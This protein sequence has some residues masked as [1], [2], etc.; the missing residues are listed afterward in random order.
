MIPN[1]NQFIEMMTPKGLDKNI[2]K[3]GS[4]DPAYS[5]GKPK[6]MF[7]GETVVSAK[8]YPRLASYTPV[9]SDRVLILSVANSY[10]ILGKI[11]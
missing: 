4:I 8:Q 6:V 5:S 10:V 3:L 7:D 9:A 1:V 11:I 2:Y